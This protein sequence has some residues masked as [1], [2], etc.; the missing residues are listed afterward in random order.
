MTTPDTDAIRALLEPRSIAVIGAS[1]DTTRM[2]GGLILSFLQRHGYKGALYPVNP[3]YPEV[4]GVRCYPTLAA[5]PGPIDLAVMAVPAKAILDLIGELPKGHVRTHLVISSGFAEL[6]EEGAALEARLVALAAEKGAR[7]VGP[8]CVGSANIANGAVPSISQIFDQTELLPGGVALISQSGAFGTAILAQAQNEG[9]GIGIFVSSGNEADLEFSE[10]GCYLVGKADVTA[11]AGYIESIRNG[12]RFTAF[13]RQALAADKPVVVLK[14]GRS[15]TGAMAARSHTGA[16]VGSDAVVQAVFDANGVLRAE[17]SEQFMDLLKMF[18]KTPAA[19]GKRL[20]ILSHS[21]GASVLAADAAEAAGVEIPLLPEDVRAKLKTMLP[22]FAGFNN[23]LDMTGGM[24]FDPKTMVACMREM[25]ASDAFDAAVLSVKLIWRK[26]AEL[27]EELTKL[28]ANCDK[29]FAVSWVAP[30]E[31][32][33]RDIRRAPFPVFPDPARAARI[34]A[35]RMRHDTGRARRLAL[36]APVTVPAPAPA[37]GSV[38]ELG[39]ALQTAGI[40]LPRET[41]AKDALAAEAFRRQVGA[42]VAVKIASPDIAHRTEIGAVAI[43]IDGAEALAAAVERVLA[44][45]RR[46][47]PTARI[48]GVLVQEMVTGGLEVLVGVKRDPTFGPVVA[49]GPGG[50]LVEEL[51][52]LTLVPAP[53]TAAA[54][55][56]AF[57]G[58]LLG[59][60]L[61]GVRGQPPRDGAALAATIGAVAGFALAHPEVAE[62]DLNPVMVLGA[63]K[64]CVAVDY[65]AT[66]G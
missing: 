41:L 50:T 42:A 24:S 58:T 44:N 19:R 28:R 32:A 1:P 53:V 61:A 30:S 34:L 56:A 7:I 21:G 27:I 52:A 57:A 23:P 64:G 36:L 4:A 38:A 33:V 2:G 31:E 43:G 55:E 66:L 39:R 20:A 22:P 60:L 25:L 45:A 40:R 48:D 51:K 47:H 17:D 54:V 16:L 26:G 15:N 49:F 29:P 62:L 35:A 5:A 3:K 11:I 46:H 37:I 12:P 63:G 18:S 6:G 9:V 14:V 59:R 8:N 65:K 13:A 10:Y